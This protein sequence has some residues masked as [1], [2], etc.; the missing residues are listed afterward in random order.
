MPRA[1]PLASVP[2]MSAFCLWFGALV[3]GQHLPAAVPKSHQVQSADLQAAAVRLCKLLGAEQG[4]GF[5]LLHSPACW[6]SL[7]VVGQQTQGETYLCSLESGLFPLL[8]D[9]RAA[10]HRLV[11]TFKARVHNFHQPIDGLIGVFQ[12][13]ACSGGSILDMQGGRSFR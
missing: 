3:L 11:H 10:V 12:V 1:S 4:F 9:G 6:H 7:Q 2:K 5:Q 13:V 8:Y